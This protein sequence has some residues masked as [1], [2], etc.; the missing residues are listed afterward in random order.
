[1]LTDQPESWLAECWSLVVTAKDGHAGCV[2][3]WEQRTLLSDSALLRMSLG[4]F[5]GGTILVKAQQ[6]LVI[7]PMW[8]TE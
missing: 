2:L 8:P 6:E 4:H 7:Y 5:C 3:G 1:M